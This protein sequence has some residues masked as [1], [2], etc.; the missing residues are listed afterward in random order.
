MKDIKK[1]KKQTI[2]RWVTIMFMM[3]GD[4]PMRYITSFF[5]DSR[6]GFCVEHSRCTDCPLPEFEV[7]KE[8]LSPASF[9]PIYAKALSAYKRDEKTKAIKL[10]EKLLNIVETL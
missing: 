3:L 2:D 1:A 4:I 7:C 8:L 9:T 6:C 5:S 10:V